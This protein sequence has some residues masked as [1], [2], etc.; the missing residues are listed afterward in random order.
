MSKV[1]GVVKDIRYVYMLRSIDKNTLDTLDQ[2]SKKGHED[3]KHIIVFF[4]LLIHAT[5][6]IA[7]V[8]AYILSEYLKKYTTLG[9]SA[10]SQTY[11]SLIMTQISLTLAPIRVLRCSKCH[12]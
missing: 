4:Y 11:S 6:N 9:A 5:C 10:F 7:S 12:V 8:A 3:C 1:Y 2:L